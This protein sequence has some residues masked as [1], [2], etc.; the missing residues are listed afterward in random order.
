MFRV[1]ISAHLIGS[2]VT[3][4]TI[5]RLRHE[6][7]VDMG[8][9]ENFFLRRELLQRLSI[10]QKKDSGQFAYLNYDF[11]LIRSNKGCTL[12]VYKSFSPKNGH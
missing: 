3:H 11:D 2:Y 10:R 5:I 6:E 1:T 7:P 8:I 12:S 4:E 9:L